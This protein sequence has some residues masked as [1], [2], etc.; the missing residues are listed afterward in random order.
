MP[1]LG[2]SLDRLDGQMMVA[3]SGCRKVTKPYQGNQALLSRQSHLSVNI[4]R[5]HIDNSITSERDF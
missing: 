1:R 3:K 5:S 4:S 2:N